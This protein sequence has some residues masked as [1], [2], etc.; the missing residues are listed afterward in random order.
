MPVQRGQSGDQRQGCK[1]ALTSAWTG[2]HC[3][4]VAPSPGLGPG[5]DA[6][7]GATPRAHPSAG[8]SCQGIAAGKDLCRLWVSSCPCYTSHFKPHSVPCPSTYLYPPWDI[9][10]TPVEA[11]VTWRLARSPHRSMGEGT[12]RVLEPRTVSAQKSLM[13]VVPST[14]PWTTAASFHSLCQEGDEARGARLGPAALVTCVKV[15]AAASHLRESLFPPQ[16]F[17]T[18]SP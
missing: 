14:W 9:S 17:G 1:L 6:P 2:P 16:A 12:Q 5:G 8:E 18:A 13:W 10:Q 11:R 3:P 4:R 15:P 7:P